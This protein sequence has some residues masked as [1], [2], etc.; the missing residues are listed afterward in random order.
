[1][2][3]VLEEAMLVFRP[4]VEEDLSGIMAIEQAA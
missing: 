1:M 2:S 4:M 3:A